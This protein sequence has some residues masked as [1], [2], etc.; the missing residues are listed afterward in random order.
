MQPEDATSGVAARHEVILKQYRFSSC[1]I[2]ATIIWPADL[3]ES[4]DAWQDILP[5]AAVEITRA[6][7]AEMLSTP[8]VKRIASIL[9]AD[10]NHEKKSP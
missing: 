6:S 7:W 10:E 1:D 2:S 5:G 3:S 4:T 8:A 9:N